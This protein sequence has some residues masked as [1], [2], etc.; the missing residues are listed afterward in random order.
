MTESLLEAKLTAR[1]QD[2]EQRVSTVEGRVGSVEDTVKSNSETL[3]SVSAAVW[4]GNSSDLV[5]Y[6]SKGD[7]GSVVAHGKANLDKHRMMPLKGGSYQP[8][9]ND[10]DANLLDA[11]IRSDELSLEVVLKTDVAS[12]GGPARIVS[13][14]RDANN[15]NFTRGQEGKSLGSKVNNLVF[16]LRTDKTDKNGTN[17]QLKLGKIATG[18][19]M[20]V[21]VSYRPGQL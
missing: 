2:V 13:F 7:R 14:S 12:Q 11:C 9:G 5:Y 15:R 16:R 8:G 1:N 20:H 19:L 17:P 4:P 18:K 6:W 21:V 10:V 3:K